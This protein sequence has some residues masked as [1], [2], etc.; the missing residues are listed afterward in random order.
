M[1][2]RNVFIRLAAVII[3]CSTGVWLAYTQGQ[4]PITPSKLNKI[5]ENLYELQTAYLKI[6][7]TKENPVGIPP[8][9]RSNGGNVAIYLTSEGVIV[10][11]DKFQMN[12][13]DIMTSVKSL[14]DKPVKYVLST[15]HHQ[16]HSGGHVQ[17]LAAGAQ[18]VAQRNNR[19]NMERGKQPGLPQLT[20]T[21]EASV[22][23]GG[24][25]VRMRYFGPAHTN[26]D[27]VVYFPE[28]RAI[29]T[30]D[31]VEGENYEVYVDATGGGSIVEYTNTL[32]A[33][34]KTDFV[35]VIP[36]HGPLMKK[37]DVVKYRNRVESLRNGLIS[38][39]RQNKSKDEITALLQR[40]FSF[41]QTA[42][43]DGMLGQLKGRF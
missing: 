33:L 21:D 17:F 32:D 25:E 15:H 28:E 8:E 1:L 24:K 9:G 43:I 7:G 39:L 5:S 41:Y 16:D 20:F 12:F 36:G 18:I 6:P 35:T 22:Y 14:T 34:L 3:A 27:A 23:L 29:H 26:G 37:D 30:G 40:D 31:I 42:L 19:L 4:P 11:D 13:S 10:V 2:M 38:M